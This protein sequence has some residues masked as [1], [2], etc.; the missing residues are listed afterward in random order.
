MRVR[1]V[2]V[3]LTTVVIASNAG[4][5][6]VVVTNLTDGASTCPSA[7]ACTLRGAIA[8]AMPDDSIQFAPAL[9]FPAIMQLAGT[10]L[11]I[12]K[13]LTIIGPGPEQLA[14][15]AATARRVLAV[16]SGILILEK[17]ALTDGIAL[18]PNGAS[19][20]PGSGAPGQSGQDAEGG[21]VRT[22]AGTSL[23]LRQVA[24]RSCEVAGGNGGAGGSAT[25]GSPSIGGPGGNG[26]AARGGAIFALGQL[27]LIESSV[28]SST[29]RGGAGAAGGA[30]SNA[31]FLGGGGDGGVGGTSGSARGGAIHVAAG[32]ALLIRNSTLAGNTVTTSVGGFGGNGGNG[33]AFSDGR[34]GN[35]GAGGSAAGG[36]VFLA[37]SLLLADIEFAT[38]GPAAV[39]NGPGG[40]P[41]GGSPSGA[42]GVSGVRG[43]ELLSSTTTP[44]RVL[45]SAFVGN[46]IA[47]DCEGPAVSAV[48]AS[49][50]SDDSCAGFTLQGVFATI[51]RSPIF[52]VQNG[53][54][55]LLPS[56]T[57][58]LIDS[59][60]SCN[61]LAG[62]A[63]TTDQSGKAR[64]L[65]GNSDGTAVCDVGAIEFDPRLFGNGFEP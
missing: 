29:A 62:G 9:V 61:G 34:G 58:L 42:S 55:V 64:P 25:N 13:N 21:C 52:E 46:G 33:L 65:D 31:I 47:A 44:A 20:P 12:N 36:Q 28:Q 22:S 6:T 35:G 41:G 15:R 23:L 37:G 50:D 19:A 8:F 32:G 43:G 56:P 18:V 1:S 63:V 38:L 4:A 14:V 26:G 40:F 49:V 48:G 11:T 10:E 2:W 54:A 5:A 27:T 3:A 16:T 60:S 24:L 57:S 30:G 17:I 53:R 39:V 51:F 45:A 59:A 7:S